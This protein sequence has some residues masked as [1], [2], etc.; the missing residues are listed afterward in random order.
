MTAICIFGLNAFSQTE[1]ESQNVQIGGG[2]ALCKLEGS[3]TSY[4]GFA[5]NFSYEKF[6][7]SN[8][9]IG[10]SCNVIRVKTDT[11]NEGIFKEVPFNFLAKYYVGKNKFKG[12]VKGAAGCHITRLTIKV[13]DELS[14]AT[15]AGFTAG[16]GAGM[17]Y[18]VSEHVL[19]NLDY[20]IF[21][22]GNTDFNNGLIHT[23]NFNIGY[24]F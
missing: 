21:W 3:D 6:L 5:I 4:N 17:I 7:I 20:S 24:V 8:L 18:A 2:W 19:L 14:T 16:G 10:A 23:V 11:R 22:L 15:D 12:F 9:S 1:E 13:D